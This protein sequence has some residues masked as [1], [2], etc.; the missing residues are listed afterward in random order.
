MIKGKNGAS[1]GDINN[2]FFSRKIRLKFL[3]AEVRQIII[4]NSFWLKIRSFRGVPPSPIFF[5]DPDFVSINL[6]NQLVIFGD[7]FFNQI[8]LFAVNLG[9]VWYCH[10]YLL[11][12]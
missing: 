11:I 9:V 1:C 10:R 7:G 4:F 6:I 12:T 8:N 3:Y 5:S 2:I